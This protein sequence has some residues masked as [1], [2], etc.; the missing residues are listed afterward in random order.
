MEPAEWLT[1]LKI[2]AVGSSL[3][4]AA[5]GVGILILDRSVQR[6]K[7]GKIAAL[8]TSSKT[9]VQDVEAAKAELQGKQAEIEKLQRRANTIHSI[10]VT[11]EVETQTPP[12]QITQI[13]TDI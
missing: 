3:L 4:A 8:D 12:R 2:V 10:A 1:V 13:E 7:D 9:L 6:T 11:I 5:A